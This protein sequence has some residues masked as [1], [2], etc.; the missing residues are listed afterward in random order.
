MKKTSN[1][2]IETIYHQAHQ[3]GTIDSSDTAVI[4]FSLDILKDRL[5]LLQ[6]HFPKSVLHAIAIKSNSS[7]EILEAIIK[8]GFGLEAASIE[9]VALAI[10]AGATNDQIVFDSPVKTRAEIELC[11]N[12]LPGII[13]NANSL[14]ELERYPK[15]FSGQLGLRINPLV[16]ADA[17]DFLNVS[18]K[19]SKFG[20]PISHEKA[21]VDACLNYPQIKGLHLHIGSS[22]KNYQANIEAVKKVVDLADRI[23][24][25]RKQAN[26]DSQI[27]F[28]D[29]GGGIQFDE[30]DE[31]FSMAGFVQQLNKLEIFDK[32]KVITEYGKFIH[33]DAAFVVSDI[34]YIVEGS[35][36][37]DPYT[38][39]IHVGADLFLRKVYSNLPINYPW[40]II[41][42]DKINRQLPEKLYNIAG[43]LCFAGDF[44]YHQLSIPE[45]KEGDKFVIQEMGANTLSMW[46]NHCSRK[47]PK[48][49]VC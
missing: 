41:R 29:I 22:I 31:N 19:A 43:P 37:N 5:Q 28:I 10:Q 35:S 27:E 44:L 25:L 30:A 11:H 24:L 17:P 32:Y 1:Q 23:N 20:V 38:A 45:I 21:I 33:N 9:E 16:N 49:I 48:L 14:V 36:E 34:E 13:V 26:I 12:S 8:E 46:S 39:F 40:S 42:K 18:K 7:P 47:I 15:D 6:Q 4:F 2:E 3:D